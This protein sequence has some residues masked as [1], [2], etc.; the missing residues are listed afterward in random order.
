M[1]FTFLLFVKLLII[2]QDLI[3][4][5]IKNTCWLQNTQQQH[6]LW[7][8]NEKKNLFMLSVLRQLLGQKAANQRILLLSHCLSIFMPFSTDEA[9]PDSNQICEL[10]SLVFLKTLLKFNKIIY[11]SMISNDVLVH[12]RT[13]LASEACCL[14]KDCH[15]V[16]E[17]TYSKWTVKITEITLIS[18]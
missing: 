17:F 9:K 2:S 7:E 3:Y 16:S 18:K 15:L 5:L 14:N 4:N 6:H 10:S 13:S 1:S 8:E 12:K 11:F